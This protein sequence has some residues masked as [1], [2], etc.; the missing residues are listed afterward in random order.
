MNTKLQNLI[1]WSK[2]KSIQILVVIA[3]LISTL[4]VLW[5]SIIYVIPVGH[6][7]VLYRPLRGGVDIE[8]ILREG[9]HVVF[10]WNSVVQY[11]IQLQTQSMELEVLTSDLMK[12]KVKV[13]F[14]YE[15]DSQSVAFLHKYVGP[16]YLRKIVIPE[17]T[18]T[19]RGLVGSLS[20]DE[21]YTKSIQDVRRDIAI[22]T[23]KV[24][25]DNFYPDGLKNMRMLVISDVQ[26]LEITFPKEVE[27]SVNTK[28]VERS[29]S[30]AYVFKIEAEKQE[31]KRKE[32]E[33]EGIKKFQDIIGANMS[34][35]YLRWKGIEATQNL[36]A[37]NNS[38][39]VIF[40]SGSS[41]LPL[42]LGDADKKESSTA[43]NPANKK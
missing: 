8:Q 26:L 25:I 37:S 42:I 5:P 27:D 30:E 17:V 39:I 36:A 19:T 10:P 4:I 7:G 43:P 33:A 18:A 23:D 3:L 28:L 2:E 12:S 32:I 14:Q 21:A 24:I 11:N 16:E 34:N 6:V 35:N 13:V 38:K 9:L 22:F 41:G 1:R 40:G 29:K 31:A 15:I 20:S